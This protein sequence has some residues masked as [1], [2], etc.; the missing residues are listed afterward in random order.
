M[1]V[2]IVTLIVLIIVPLGAYQTSHGKSVRGFP[3][4]MPGSRFRSMSAAFLSSAENNMSDRAPPSGQY[5]NREPRST[6]PQRKDTCRVFVSGVIGTDPREAFLSNGHYVINFALAVV[7]HFNPVHEWERYKPTE[8]MWMGAE[9]WDDMARKHQTMITKGT[10]ISALG[11]MIHNKWQDKVTGEDRK[12]FKL[13]ITHIL[14]GEEMQEMLG[15]SGAL[16]MIEE[17]M[18]SEQKFDEYSP[19][20]EDQTMNRGGSGERFSRMDDE[21]GGG[22]DEDD[23]IPF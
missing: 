1:F 5:E 13:R 4:L 10:P 6:I 23:M 8:T 14:D 2:L 16:D 15:A 17:S 18:Q 11:Y 22:A 12:T 7:G 20:M 9:I 19:D 21:L 3:A